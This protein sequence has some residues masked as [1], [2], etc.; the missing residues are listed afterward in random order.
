MVNNKENILN[1]IHSTNDINLILTHR[2]LYIIQKKFEQNKEQLKSIYNK[3]GEYLEKEENLL[4]QQDDLPEIVKQIFS[5]N[6]FEISDVA[7][8]KEALF[9][10]MEYCKEINTEQYILNEFV[11]FIKNNRK[12]YNYIYR[13][14]KN[15]SNFNLDDYANLNINITDDWTKEGQV[16]LFE[17]DDEQNEIDLIIKDINNRKLKSAKLKTKLILE[18]K[19]NMNSLKINLDLIKKN[20]EEVNN[21]KD[22]AYENSYSESSARISGRKDLSSRSKELGTNYGNE[23]GK[24]T[25]RSNIN[26]KR[27]D[28]ENNNKDVIPENVDDEEDKESNNKGKEIKKDS[29]KNKKEENNEEEEEEGDEEEEEEKEEEEEEEDDEEENN[30]EEDSEKDEKNKG[31]KNEKKHREKDRKSKEEIKEKED[32]KSDKKNI[33]EFKE[34]EDSEN[35][36]KSEE[37]KNDLD[38]IDLVN[39]EKDSKTG[40]KDSKDNLLFSSPNKK[41]IT[42]LEKVFYPTN[43]NKKQK[44]IKSIKC[45]KYYLYVDIIPLI[46]ADFISDQRNLYVVIDHSDDLRNNLTSIFDSEIL[47][48]LG[49]D[50]FEEVLNEMLNKISE[51]RKAKF[52]VE[53][54]IENY[55]KLSEKMKRKNQDLTYINITLKKLKDFFNWLNTKIFTMQNNIKQLKEFEKQ[56]KEEHERIFGPNFK[57]FTKDKLKEKKDKLIEDYKQL[58]KDLEIRKFMIQKKKRM[59]LLNKSSKINL[60]PIINSTILNNS[61]NNISNIEKDN[62]NSPNLSI[63]SNEISGDDYKNTIV[64]SEQNL[65]IKKNPKAKNFNYKSNFDSILTEKKIESN[66][67]EEEEKEGNDEE[68]EGEEEKEAEE[69]G[70]KEESEKK[71][72]NEENNENKNIKN[73]EDINDYNDF[74]SNNINNN[75]LSESNKNEIKDE[76]S[77]EKQEK[78]KSK[79]NI[80]NKLN[81]EKNNLEENLDNSVKELN[82]DNKEEVNEIKPNQSQPVKRNKK[83]KLMLKS[84]VSKN[85][86]NNTGINTNLISK[87]TAVTNESEVNE[88]NYN[89]ISTNKLK[90]NPKTTRNS[91]NIKKRVNYILKKISKPEKSLTKDELREEAIKDIFNFYSSKKSNNPTSFESIQNNKSNL[92]INSFCKFCNDFKIPLTKDKILSLFNKSISGDSR[93]MNLQEFKLCLISMSFEINKAQ[94]DEVNRSINIFIGKVNQKNKDKSRFEKENKKEKEKNKEIINKKLKLIEEY[95]NKSEEELIEDLFKFMEIDDSDKYKQKMNGGLGIEHK[96][97]NLPKIK[98]PN[99]N[100]HINNK[101]SEHSKTNALLTFNKVEKENPDKIKKMKIGMRIWVKGMIEKERNETPKNKKIEYESEESKEEEEEKEEEKKDE[102]PVI[103]SQGIPLFS[104]NKKKDEK[105]YLYQKFS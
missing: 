56:K 15:N 91:K 66:D 79:E 19:E 36:K 41:D 99:N 98:I 89:I 11:D 77:E 17:D 20:N 28:E 18:N 3:Y 74:S 46:I 29:K 53:K 67:G 90:T 38:D 78:E 54:N 80:E 72:V 102:L 62:S 95:Q 59:S 30:E 85:K 69:E 5:V 75:G 88:N 76:E 40:D 63:N 24:G 33:K 70:K 57:K 48:K 84:N 12:K 103:E 22:K 86:V 8:F 45:I 13:E 92:N 2:S 35:D 83:I 37:K 9:K 47:Y 101:K 50:N 65:S 82:I 87:N 94:I 64:L 52:K 68:K 73:I 61:N 4:I 39:I 97:L 96:S 23:S 105:K 25:H 44:N 42:N 60:K 1:C 26:T 49:E 55:E 51:Y 43:Y 6:K 34:K 93:V 27:K 58:K 14:K 31:E 81:E 16:N 21:E 71:E 100:N 32:S 10:E 104:R 7:S